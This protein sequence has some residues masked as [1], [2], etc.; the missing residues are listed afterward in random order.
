[1]VVAQWLME[2]STWSALYPK[3]QALVQRLQALGLETADIVY[4]DDPHSGQ[5]T[6]VDVLGPGTEVKGDNYHGLNT[7][8]RSLPPHC[9]IKS[10]CESSMWHRSCLTK[11]IIICMALAAMD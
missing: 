11:A 7:V 9:S 1:M 2:D 4:M 8:G 3:L 5:S 6:I 10:E